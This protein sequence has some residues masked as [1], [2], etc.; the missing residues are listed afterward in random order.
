MDNDLKLGLEDGTIISNEQIK[1]LDIYKKN[2]NY[3]DNILYILITREQSMY[4]YIMS[5]LK[6]LVNMFY[7]N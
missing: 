6:S 7:K 2:R 4:N 3:N 1:I 5:I